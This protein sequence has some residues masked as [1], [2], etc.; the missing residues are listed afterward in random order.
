LH[1]IEKTLELIASAG[2]IYDE[3]INN[4]IQPNF[5][6]KNEL[7]SELAVSFLTNRVKVQQAL[8]NNYFLYY[9][10]RACKSQVHSN[11]SGFNKNTRIKDYTQEF[12]YEIVDDTDIEIKKE[13]EKKYIAIDKIYTTIPKTYFQEWLWHE[14]FT[15]NKTFR[16]IAKENEISHTLV[17]HEVTKIKKE[18]QR[19][20]D[21][22][23]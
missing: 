1:T 13:K 20:F 4:I 7:I 14:Y 2:T 23:K 12:N 8:D 3:I 10:I 11:T 15:F 6:L 9:F 17:F 16:Q 22:I 19:K 21:I 18:I 5:H